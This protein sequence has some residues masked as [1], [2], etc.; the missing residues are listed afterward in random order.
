MTKVLP[1]ILE[2]RAPQW[3][4]WT[5]LFWSYDWR[6]LCLASSLHLLKLMAAVLSLLTVRRNTVFIIRVYSKIVR[7]FRSRKCIAMRHRPMV[8]RIN[9]W[10]FLHGHNI[11]NRGHR[12]EIT[13]STP[14]QHYT[15]I[16]QQL[17][18]TTL[19]RYTT[20]PLHHY[21]TPLHHY[22]TTQLHH[23]TTATIHHYT[24]TLLHYY[25]TPLHH[26]NYTTTPLHHYTNT[27]HHYTCILLQLTPLHHYTIT[28]LHYTT[29]PPQLYTTTPLHYY[30]TPP[31][32]CTI[33]PL[34]L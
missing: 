10:F 12:T 6:S 9:C 1:H 21:T 4:H 24:T 33:T 17:Y 32:Y 16:L 13:V 3:G 30:T 31:H 7:W 25:T 27:L 5:R 8:L 15:T 28:L 11:F 29:T 20:T 22:T 2:V 23:Y 19:L 14:L 18:T 34:H 26:H